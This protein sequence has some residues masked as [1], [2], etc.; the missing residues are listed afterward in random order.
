LITLIIVLL[1]NESPN[2]YATKK[3]MAQI[4]LPTSFSEE[5]ARM[6]LV[7]I[8]ALLKVED[9]SSIDDDDDENPSQ[10]QGPNQGQCLS[11]VITT[12][13]IVDY[14]QTR[15]SQNAIQ[16]FIANHVDQCVMSY[17][18]HVAAPAPVV[19]PAPAPPALVPVLAAVVGATPVVISPVAAL[20][21]RWDMILR[22]IPQV[23]GGPSQLGRMLKDQIHMKLYE[24]FEEIKDQTTR[25]GIRQVFNQQARLG[26][27]NPD[28]GLVTL[29]P[30]P[31][32]PN[33]L[34]QR[35]RVATANPSAK[36]KRRKQLQESLAICPSLIP[37]ENHVDGFLS[38]F[39]L[40][41]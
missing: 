7:T 5:M 27:Y 36:I 28:F 25:R 3:R 17:Q 34:K 15:K 1:D 19:A 21:T 32:S 35:K 39:I 24:I 26:T 13:T 41:L 30:R 29:P 8:K 18:A 38:R 6:C 9:N 4:Q 2:Q 14:L 22:D 31:L 23:T 10:E 33:Q 16:A 12:K 40:A 20:V 11:D 37:T